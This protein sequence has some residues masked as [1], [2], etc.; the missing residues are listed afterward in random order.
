VD[1]QRTSSG[2]VPKSLA[3]HLLELMHNSTRETEAY[4]AGLMPG[5]LKVLFLCGASTPVLQPQQISVLF[6]LEPVL[7]QDPKDWVVPN[8]VLCLVLAVL[9]LPWKPSTHRL[10]RLSSAMRSRKENISLAF[11]EHSS[12]LF[13]LNKPS[14]TF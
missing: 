1:R 3:E 12:I 5:G 10:L 4:T 6:T 13:L 14:A 11:R 7:C 9:A 2:C 8:P